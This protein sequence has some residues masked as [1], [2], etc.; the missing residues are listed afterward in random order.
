MRRLK[1][2]N[3]TLSINV[4]GNSK[5]DQFG[6]IMQRDFKRRILRRIEF[7]I[8]VTPCKEYE[9]DKNTEKSCNVGRSLCFFL[10][11]NEFDSCKM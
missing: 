3:S 9:N 1:Q 5:C 4:G 7:G 6:L 11:T 10:P 8:C 2:L